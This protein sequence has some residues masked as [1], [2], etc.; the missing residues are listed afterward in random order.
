MS[1]DSII[2]LPT[3]N[4][5]VVADTIKNTG[6]FSVD[7]PPAKRYYEA[8]PCEGPGCTNTVPPGFYPAQRIRSFCSK[9]C[10]NS[11]AACRY[12]IGTCL[13][14]CGGQVLGHK[15]EAGK[16][17][18]CCDDHMRA[19]ELERILSPTGPF[20]PLIEEY[21][22]TQA[23]NYYAPGTLHTVRSSLAKF[24]RHAVQV[25]EIKLLDDIRSSA[26]TRLIAVERERGLT[27]RNFV[28]YL[29]TFFGWLIAEERYD[30]AN[31]VVSR[32]HSQKGAPAE[33]RP[34]NNRDL[35]AIWKC[36]ESSGKLELMLAFTIGEE[37]GLRVGEVAN[38]RLSDVDELAQTIFVRLPTKNSRTRTVPFHGKVKKYL[39]LWL[40]KRDPR[41][42]HDHLLHN[43]VSNR[44]TQNQLDA[45]F[46]NLLREEPD[47]AGSF[48]FHRLRHSWATNLMNNG[49]ELAVLKELGGW[50]NWNSMQRYIK[51]LEGTVRRQYEAAYAKLQEQQESGDDETLSLI[52]FALMDE[53]DAATS[54]DS[55]T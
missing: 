41:C 43:T 38:I 50:M 24:F 13:C 49:M 16:K 32:I 30:R 15:K 28:G 3:T 21:M 29:S 7:N 53:P 1:S 17:L 31:P 10:R 26:I 33:A 37:C 51:V 35:E 6:R 36:V 42:V 39:T 48:N 55:A 2:S 47:P 54:A 8:A 11:D 12:V 52:D 19:Y 25:E 40:A 44:F 9:T 46:N 27:S 22:A 20:R 34:Y 4:G 14:G 18:F 45:W 5:E 23:P